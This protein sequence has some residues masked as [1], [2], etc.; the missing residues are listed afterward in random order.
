LITVRPSARDWR[1]AARAWGREGNERLTASVGLVLFVLLAVEAWTT[2]SLHAY[3]PLHMFLGFV[4]L[5]PVALKLGSIGW[6]AAR[7]Y[8]GSRPY[9]LAGPP[10]LPLRLLA[11]LLVAS[12]LALFASGVALIVAGHGRGWIQMVHAV[13][14]GVWGVLM[15]IHVVAYLARAFRLG[16][17]D[18]RRNAA[19]IVP[20]A[21][22]RRALLAGALLAGLVIALATH[23]AQQS[24]HPRAQ[25]PGRQQPA[26]TP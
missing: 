10:T 21:R 4:L 6:R 23:P 14:F 9:R 16:T 7:Y 17:A 3:L 18:V 2:F 25:E 20:G 13:S 5:P 26:G 15:I 11:P 1:V 22:A 19:R 8:A 24:F 12:T